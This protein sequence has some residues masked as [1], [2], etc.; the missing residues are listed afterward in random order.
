LA[1]L[2]AHAD[3]VRFGTFTS[4][5]CTGTCA[6]N[7]NGPAQ[8]S[9]ATVK[10]TDNELGTLNFDFTLLNGNRFANGGQ[11]V[12]FGFN[13]I[14]NPE[15]TYSGLD[16]SLFIVPGGTG[17]NSLIQNAGSLWRMGSATSNTELMAKNHPSMVPALSSRS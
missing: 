5:H 6:G 9:F 17:T 2:P 10:V 11:D 1:A 12:V 4:D 3:I 14:G 13:L 7:P 15:I 16:T 8:T